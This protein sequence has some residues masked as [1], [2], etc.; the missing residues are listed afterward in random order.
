MIQHAISWR[1]QNLVL[2]LAVGVIGT[3]GVQQIGSSTYWVWYP[4]SYPAM[5]MMGSQVDKQQHAMMLAAIVGVALLAVSAV[6][7][8]RREVEN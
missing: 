1:F 5:A 3:M 6:L 2:P 4:W 7:L 8:G